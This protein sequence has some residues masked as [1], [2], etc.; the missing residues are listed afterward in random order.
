MLVR[1]HTFLTTNGDGSNLVARTSYTT[2]T[3]YQ[4]VTMF[5]GSCFDAACSHLYFPESHES[6]ND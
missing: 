3:D 2:T 5:A 1:T 4:N 6:N